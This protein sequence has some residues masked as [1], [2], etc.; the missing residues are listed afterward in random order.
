M[1]SDVQAHAPSGG[2]TGR[3]RRQHDRFPGP[4]DGFR[5]GALETPLRIFDLSRGGCFVNAMHE[6]KPGVSFVMKIELPYV[7]QITVKAVTLYRR[8]AFGFA[9]KFVEMSDEMTSRLEEAL[10][11]L[12]EREPY[13]E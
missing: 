7:G 11:Q 10:E 9:M 5:V 4:F 1:I 8:P 12:Q 2:A 3:D 13:D 6:Q